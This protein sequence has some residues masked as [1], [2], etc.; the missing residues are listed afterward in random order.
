MTDVVTPMNA[1]MFR[2][3]FS[4][5]SGHSM[6]CIEETVLM[7]AK[8]MKG[9]C[10]NADLPPNAVHDILAD[11][12]IEIFEKHLSTILDQKKCDCKKLFI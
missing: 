10:D 3:Q 7:M 12:E 4:V 6:E 1:D 11:I 2:K 5:T 9:V 8:M